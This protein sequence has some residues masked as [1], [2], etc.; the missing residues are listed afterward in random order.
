MVVIE[1]NLRVFQGNAL[2]PFYSR[3]CI[4]SNI[5][6]N[7]VRNLCVKYVDTIKYNGIKNSNLIKY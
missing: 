6:L 3:K 1:E 5:H 2:G 4:H 7:R